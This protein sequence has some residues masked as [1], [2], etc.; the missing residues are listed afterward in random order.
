MSQYFHPYR[1]SGRN[2]NVELYLSS[3][4]TKTYLKNV[5]HV[6]VSRFAFKKSLANLKTE[7]D[8][9][10]ISK[11]APVP[12]NLAKLSNAVK[13]DV[14]KKTVYDK[15]VTKVD[16]IDT[17]GFVLKTKYDT[18]ISNLEKKISD[19]ETKIPD[20]DSLVK[21]TDYNSKITEIGG[22]IL[23]VSNLVKKKQQ[24]IM[25][26]LLKLKINILLLLIRIN[27]LKVLLIIVLKAKI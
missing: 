16:N 11:L 20:T 10:D 1:T 4:E 27:S 5:V 2:I 9:L 26:K 6:D 23:N 12:D 25:Q 13:N 14:V 3:Y 24:I 19:T 15:L 22:K 7:V 18:D 8:N 17:A 21:T